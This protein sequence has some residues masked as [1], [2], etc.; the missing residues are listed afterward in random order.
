MNDDTYSNG[1]SHNGCLCL[2]PF[3]IEKAFFCARKKKSWKKCVTV[4]MILSSQLSKNKGRKQ[5]GYES[6]NDFSDC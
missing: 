3:V 1:S 5:Y 4:V 2:S 6:G